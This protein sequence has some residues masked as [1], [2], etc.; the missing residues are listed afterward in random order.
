MLEAR[1]CFLETPQGGEKVFQALTS[2]PTGKILIAELAL[3]ISHDLDPQDVRKR[4]TPGPE[5]PPPTENT[6]E[7]SSSTDLAP[8][9]FHAFASR[10]CHDRCCDDRFQGSQGSETPNDSQRPRLKLTLGTTQLQSPMPLGP[11]FSHTRSTSGAL[12]CPAGPR[13]ETKRDGRGPGGL[14][15]SRLRWGFRKCLLTADP[16]RIKTKLWCVCIKLI[17]E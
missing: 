9:A 10:L 4:D 14:H 2:S 13:V 5:A 1:F 3:G 15:Y 7:F 16:V 11:S 17:L 8:D 12:P 6:T